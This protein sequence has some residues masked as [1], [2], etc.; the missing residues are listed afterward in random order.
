MANGLSKTVTLKVAMGNYEN[1]EISVTASVDDVEQFGGN[2]L[3]AEYIDTMIKANM[4]K[5]LQEF[6]EVTAE[7]RSFL[8]KLNDD[9]FPG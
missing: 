2:L 3:A 9:R 6:S 4:A 1:A 7:K 8:A 5:D